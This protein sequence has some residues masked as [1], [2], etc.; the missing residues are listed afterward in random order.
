MA[1]WSCSAARA[2]REA[3]RALVFNT[4]GEDLLHLDRPN[5]EFAGKPEQ[6]QH[7]QALGVPAPGP[8]RSVRL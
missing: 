2:S 6:Y 5:S 3:V 8:F 7:W 1:A 4:K